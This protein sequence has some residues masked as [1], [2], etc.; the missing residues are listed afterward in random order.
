MPALALIALLMLAAAGLASCAV[1]GAPPGEPAPSPVPSAEGTPRRRPSP[2]PTAPGP[3]A[4]TPITPPAGLASE[5]TLAFVS[6]RGGQTDLWLIDIATRQLWRLTHDAAI[7]SFPAWSPDGRMLAYVVEDERAVRNLW[8]LDLRAGVHRQ[9][10]REEPPFNVRRAAW[11]RGGRALIYDTGKPFDR[12]PELRVV[13]TEGETLAPLLP[14][15]GEVVH[16]WSTDGATLVCAVGDPLGEPRIV[17]T[18]A[19]PGAAL[20]PDEGAPVGFA[21]ELSPDGAYT[22]FSGPPLSNDQTTFVLDVISG[23]EWPLN[24]T[25]RGRRYEHDFAWSPDARRLVFVHGAGGV[26]DGQGRLKTGAGPPPTSDPAVGLWIVERGAPGREPEREQ[27]TIGSAD[28]APRWSPDGRWIAYLSDVV[29]PSPLESNIW[30]IAA[31]PDGQGW[32]R[33]INLTAGNGNNW[34]PA[35]MPLP[36][37]GAGGR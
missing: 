37:G 5:R 31:E 25:V 9:L 7:E 23:R 24:A 33:Q 34:S 27:L 21:V 6:D 12:R 35:W 18:E 29:P 13:T 32:R 19:V 11:L 8:T 1:A 14:P 10:T 36:H 17:A 16:D 22:T 20:R 4:P 3:A 30:L 15:S 2:V 28:A 26:T